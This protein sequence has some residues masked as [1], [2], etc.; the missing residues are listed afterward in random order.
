MTPIGPKLEVNIVEE[1][2]T[3]RG[4]HDGGAKLDAGKV[5]AWLV[6][7][8]FSRALEEVARVGTLGAEKYSPNGWKEVPDAVERYSDAMVRHM[9]AEAQGEAHDPEMGTL[10]A[11]HVA[12]NALARLEK[13]LDGL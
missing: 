1:D 13:M 11:A 3:G 4:A 9:F 10:H 5:R 2:P 12:W 8:G 7:G 6:L